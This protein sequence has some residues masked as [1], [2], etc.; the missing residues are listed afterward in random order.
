MAETG[1]VVGGGPE[2][3][4]VGE[5]EGWLAVLLVASIWEVGEAVFRG[6]GAKVAVY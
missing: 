3:I 6:E 4:R 2:E 5:V 1:Q